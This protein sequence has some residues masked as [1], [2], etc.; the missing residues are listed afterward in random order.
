MTTDFARRR[1]NQ[2]VLPHL[3][4]AFGLARWLTGNR[5]DA[6]DVVR[7]KAASAGCNLTSLMSAFRLAASGQPTNASTRQSAADAIQRKMSSSAPIRTK[8]SAGVG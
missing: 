4:V 3:D 5:T 1:F 7:L 2:M 8:I 6:E